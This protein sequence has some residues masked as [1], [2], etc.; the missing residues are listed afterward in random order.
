MSRASAS[1][2]ALRRPSCCARWLLAILMASALPACEGR[3]IAELRYTELGIPHIRAADYAGLGFGLGYAQ[4]RENLCKIELGMLAFSGELSRHFGPDAAGSTLASVP[5]SLAS[6]QYFQGLN[7]SGVIERLVRQRAPLGPRREVRQ[8]VAGY[9]DGFN[10]FLGERHPRACSKA[11]WL[12][13][14]TDLDVYRRIY[15]VT[16]LMGQGLLAAGAI[17]AA[18]PPLASPQ[19]AGF[20]GAQRA[21][22]LAQ[23]QRFGRSSQLPASNAVGLGAAA[24]ST[25]GGLNVANPH[26]SWDMDMRWFQ[27][28]LTVPGEIDVSGATLIGAPLVVMGHTASVA[29]SITTAEDA[30]RFTLFELELAPGSTTDYMVDGRAEAMERREVSVQSLRPDGKLE[31]ITRDQ[32]W[33]RYGPVLG[34]GFGAFEL[35]P[36]S[37]A[38]GDQPGRAYVFRDAN[39]S[40]MRML[41][42]LFAFDHARDVDDILDAVRDT[43]GVPWWTVI[44]A[45]ARGRT[46]FSQMHVVPNVT[47]AHAA[48]CNSELGRAVFAGSGVAVLDGTRSA[49]DWKSDADAVEPG[50]FG[51]G[52]RDAPRM[53]VLLDAEWVENSNNSHWLPNATQ[54]ITGLPRILGD[55]VTARNLRTRGALTEIG[56]QLAT[57]PFTR[58]AMQDL[59][60][61]NRSHAGE[62]AVGDTVAACRGL[63]GGMATS[64]TGESVDVRAG[65]EALASWDRR[66]NR[67]SRGAL[68]FDRYWR[69]MLAGAG[70]PAA[71]WT[72]AF[73]PADPIGT[74]HTLATGG[75]LVLQALADAVAELDAAGIRVDAAL[76]DHQYIERGGRR[77]ALG[78]GG[79]PDGLGVFNILNAPFDPER[80]YVGPFDGSGYM[81]V[82][83][84]DGTPCPDAVT[85]LTYSQ[86]DDPASAHHSDQTELYA[87]KHW[88]TARFCD[89]DI[90][91]SPALEVLMVGSR[92]SKW[93]SRY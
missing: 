88:V 78:G 81:H 11:A 40:N 63:A 9:V 90:D 89:A 48:E 62:L 26:L 18:E 72:V 15:A 31:T 65:C 55:E 69:R 46:L 53:A 75:P 50:I 85:L 16:L 22:A 4:A 8:M 84:F 34:P 25:G 7:Q 19:S 58:Q 45:D 44:A 79:G 6:D 23:A 35:P 33:T 32:W 21:A 68:L 5:N 86:S 43:Q 66:M 30:R 47:D 61:S 87:Q 38:A 57:G 28:Q 77:I 73:D 27:A 74:P 82:V 52:E 39:A 91:A 93:E 24:S 10:E 71:L 1:R 80:G 70:D 2:A 37:A 20:N 12:R 60:L 13:P 42:T 54:R 29:W 67:D 59:V 76:G 83:Q 17:V 41:N 3:Y 64:S 92:D 36:W 51:P 56:E 49:C 14:M